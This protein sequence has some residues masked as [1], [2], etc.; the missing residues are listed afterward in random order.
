MTALIMIAIEEAMS[1]SDAVTLVTGPNE[2]PL[3]YLTIIGR[4]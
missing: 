2:D 1:R 4:S 3:I